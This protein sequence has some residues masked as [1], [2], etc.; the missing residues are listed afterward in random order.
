MTLTTCSGCHTSLNPLGY[1]LENFDA[2]GRHRTTENGA[3]IDASGT[4]D[5]DDTTRWTFSGPRE[6]LGH[7]ASSQAL[8][9]CAAKQF[10]HFAHGRQSAPEEQPFV[11]ALADETAASGGTVSQLVTGIIRSPRFTRFLRESAP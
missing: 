9:A 1:A 5:L 4:L 11:D 10:F 2:T 3:T 7:V 8:T 6:F